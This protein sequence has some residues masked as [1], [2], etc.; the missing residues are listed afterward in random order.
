MAKPKYG[1][2]LEGDGLLKI[3]AWARDGLTEEQIANNMGIAHRTLSVWKNEHPPIMQ[4][5]Q[6]GK[7]V[8]DI[9]VEN[10]LF[11]NAIGYEYEEEKTYIQEVDGK[12]TKRKEITKKIMPPNV[13]AQIFWLKNRK[14]YEWRD[15]RVSVVEATIEKKNPYDELTV[16]ELRQL[17]NRED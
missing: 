5:L 1:P 17:I 15:K 8:V 12:I 2:W 11:K 14:T 7:E 13:T 9:E 3:E 16:D 10:A 6:R 4:A